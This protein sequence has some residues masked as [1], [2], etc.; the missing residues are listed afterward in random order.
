[1]KSE[2]KNCKQKLIKDKFAA[3]ATMPPL[4]KDFLPRQT[5]GVLNLIYFSLIYFIF[6]LFNLV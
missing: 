3:A 6:I 1:M 5:G 4:C 2:T